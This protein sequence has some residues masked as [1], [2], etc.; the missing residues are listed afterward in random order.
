[1]RSLR[2]YLISG[3]LLLILYIIAQANRPK[4]IDW[5]ESL[6]DKEKAPYGTYILFDRLKD[7]FPGSAVTAYRQPVYN[8]IAED[9]V[10]NASYLIIAQNINEFSKPD[11][12]QLVKYVE[13]GNNVFIAS[14]YF[15]KTFEKYLDIETK[16][17]LELIG[18]NNPVHFV[19]P[20]LSPQNHYNIGKGAGSIYFSR[21][22]TLKAVVLG[23]NAHHQA[24][25]I[26]FSF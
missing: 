25:F 13:A 26:K 11:Y 24:N 7:I 17:Y 23:E 1:M 15:G 21:F 8:V 19:N 16:E 10:A 6:I 22:D 14:E 5:S 12:E 9:S 18:N 2:I 20:A 4:T 3:G